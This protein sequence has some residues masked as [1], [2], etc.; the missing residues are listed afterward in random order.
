MNVG[1][2]ITLGPGSATPALSIEDVFERQRTRAIALRV[3]TAD[4]RIATLRRLEKAILGRRAAIYAALAADLHKPEAEADLSEI[5]PILS[6]IR[7]TCRHLKSWMAPRRVPATLAMLGTKAAIRHE[8]K[9]VSLIISPWNYPFNLTFGPL[10][11][12]IGAGC[13]AIIKPSELTPHSAALMAEIVRDTFAPDDV[14]LFEGDASVATALLDLPFDHI[15]FTGS[16]AVGKVVMAAAAKHL[17]SVTLEL[18]GK[19]PVIVDE[20]ADLKKSARSIVWGKFANNGQTCIAPDYA[21]VHESR[22]P[23]FIDAA[24]GAIAAMYGDAA[25]SPD[26]CRIVNA[27]HF[28]RVRNLID[29]A[30]TRGATIHAGG[31]ADAG[32]NFVAP[33]LLSNVSADSLIMQEEIFGPVLPILP[34]GDLAMPVREINARPKPLALYVYTKDKAIADRVITETS[35]GGSCVNASMAHFLHANLPFGGVNNSGI[36][37]A[38]GFYGFRAFSHERAVLS[39]KFSATPMLFPPYS[40][41]VKQMIKMTVKFFT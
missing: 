37:N 25:A 17:A 29:D 30:T 5:M 12:A 11:S 36:G 23:Q 3:S 13:T 35:A 22:M 1:S 14:A 19:S 27:R 10:A 31:T 26:Y 40:G 6:E 24:R 16:P 4:E 2:R 20:T 18:G 9:G 8:P 41:R 21:Y 7:H 33:T 28:A 38:H 32:Q 34:Y 15:F 39:D